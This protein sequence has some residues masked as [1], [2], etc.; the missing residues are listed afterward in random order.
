MKNK[1]QLALITGAS[2]GI[3]AEI[4]VTL[5]KRGFAVALVC[6]KNLA[7]AQSLADALCD[8]GYRAHAFCADVAD[9]AAVAALFDGVRAHFGTFPD[10]LINNAG[11]AAA[12]VLADMTH[13]DYDAL[14]DTNM[15]GVFHTCR[16]VYDHMVA[17]KWGRIVNISSMWG[18]SGASCEVLYSASKAAVIGFTKA[19][20]LE[21]A[22]S[23]VTVNAIAPGVIDTDM[24]ACYDG[25][26]LAALAM[27]TPLG[28]LGTPKDIAAAVAYLVSDGASFVTG[29]VL[30]VNGGFIT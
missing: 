9:E 8:E 6:K 26:A 24:L 19:L 22:P 14:F 23:G 28:R 21:L 10:I 15:R 11:I 1:Q 25:E 13:A 16:A 4:A 2:R 27:E 30:S 17:R 7:K 12:G 5:A 29:Q 20:A 3:G 18:I